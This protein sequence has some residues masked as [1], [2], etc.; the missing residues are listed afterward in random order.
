MKQKPSLIR[1][2]LIMSILAAMLPMIASIAYFE[3]VIG[4]SLRRSEEENVQA[5]ARQM[6]G[7]VADKMS[8]LN[9]TAQYL[10]ANDLA[11]RI[12]EKDE[13]RYAASQLEKQIDTMMTYSDAWGRKFIQSLYLFRN[14]GAVFATVRDSVYAGAR[15]RNARVYQEHMDFSSTRTLLRPEGSARCYYL[16]DYY[17]TDIQ[18]RTGKLVIE[19]NPERLM[20]DAPLYGL[21]EGSLLALCDESGRI[22]CA[23]SEKENPEKAVERAK[24]GAGYYHASADLG[25]YAM[26]LQVYAPYREMMKPVAESRAA[27]YLMHLMMLSAVI[28]V[29]LFISLKLRPHR[30]TLQTN[31]EKL[32]GGDFSVRMPSSRFRE[33]DLTAR[34]FNHATDQL[35]ALFRQVSEAGALLSR[36]EYQM[37]ESQIDPHFIMNV[38]ETVNMRCLL[39]GE[40]ETAALVVD[41]GELLRSN[42]AMKSRQKLPLRQEMRYVRYYLDLQKARFEGLR[43]RLDV[44]DESLLDCLVPK[45]TL[46]PVVENSFVHGLEK[47]GRAGEIRVSVWEEESALMLRV[48]DNGA[49][50]DAQQWETSGAVSSGG[51]RSSGV[52]LR[53][54]RRRI[55]L[56]YGEGYGL[57]VNSAVGEGTTVTLTL[58]IE[59][60]KEEKSGV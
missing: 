1:M 29:I 42:V 41:L 56:L 16:Q 37:L 46:Q 13:G 23:L 36:A 22:L 60:A 49:G 57:Q 48:Q 24:E 27:F 51:T 54:I 28:A 31:L 21:P 19:V 30:R 14:D 8:T 5:A 6:A 50:F 20:G 11:Q 45:L 59:R 15:K 3:G 7:A 10:M 17:Q 43:Y 40:K 53:N 35:G 34:A 39:A 58:P 2:L 52:A 33:N 4:E 32:A 25:R 55:A 9:H 38:L 44:E 47:C 26:R 12:M 18:K